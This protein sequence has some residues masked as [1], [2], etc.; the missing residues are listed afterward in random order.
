MGSARP[1]DFGHWSAHKLEQLSEYKLRHGEAVAIGIAL[2]TIYSRN[3]G[4]LAAVD[5]ERVLSLL[6][7]LHFDLYA[8][9]L[10]HADS[11]GQPLVLAGIEEFREHLGGELTLTLLKAIG[12]GIEVHELR[13]PKLLDAAR[14]LEERHQNRGH[15]VLRARG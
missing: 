6:E 1:L 4:L 2:D 8:H 11:E 12:Q 10:A 13:L 5:A 9:E 3:I 14:E 7:A 15:K